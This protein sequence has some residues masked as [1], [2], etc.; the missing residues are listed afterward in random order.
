MG[1]I[2]EGL[3][4]AP[5]VSAAADA[6]EGPAWVVG[7]AVRDAALGRAVIDAD[8]AVEPGREEPAAKA[9]ANAAGGAAFRLS[10]EFGTWRALSGDRAWHV[11]VT[12]L[13]G[14]D[15]EADLALRDFT[16]N[17]VAVPLAKLEAEP[18][19]PTGGLG[20][21]ERRIVRAASKSTFSDDPLRLL[22]A[23]RIAASLDFEV[24]PETLELARSEARRAA[25]PAGER[26]LAEL[27]LLVAS[28]DPIRAFD[29]LDR[30]GAT[31]G[32]LPEL[33]ALH[34]VAQNPNHHL[35][36][37]G[38]TIEVLRQLLVV[39]G[40]LETY[41]GESAGRVRELLA[42]PLG[43]GFTRREGLRLGALMHDIGKP[44]TKGE[45]SGYVTFIGH[46][47][48]GA[49]LVGESLARLKAS[50]SL[51]RYVQGL[52][53][54]HLHLG[55]MVHERPLPPRRL[56]EYLAKC[57][58][59]APDVTLLTAADRMSAR[60]SGAVA[61]PE[62]IAAHLELVREV[63][64]AAL[65]WHRDGPPGVPIPGDE[66]A[67]ELGIE[68][69]PRLGELIEELR[70]AVFAGEVSDRAGA[71]EHARRALDAAASD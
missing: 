44:A 28:D 13:R 25:E 38:H 23:A 30:L 58:D 54:N 33:E 35:D 41:A 11:D 43:D 63:L 59:V 71:I 47:S 68:E 15:L 2:A 12:R 70:S 64:P 49:D 5:A 40:D 26:R 29:L 7:G 51:S 22:R 50:R 20:D 67:S 14:D 57:G 10:D 36:V 69:G 3:R 4:A 27:R 42:E 66:L 16:V 6:I 1:L 18:L 37:H 9:I 65:D 8:L 17:A 48:V 61:A 24:E 52:T 56:Y 32:V 60:G 39:E 55:F 45:Y 53:R 19:D 62:M 21:L 31:A 34:G 46:D